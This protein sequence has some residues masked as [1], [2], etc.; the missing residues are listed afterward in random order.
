MS[1]ETNTPPK[2]ETKVTRLYPV[3]DLSDLVA[4]QRFVRRM[5]DE[6][7]WRILFTV[8]GATGVAEVTIGSHP[9]KHQVEEHTVIVSA[10]GYAQAVD[11]VEIIDDWSEALDQRVR[12]NGASV[13]AEDGS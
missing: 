11:R 10:H 8:D 7:G 9:V 13:F 1:D 6:E 12:L 4:V 3:P 5:I 2:P